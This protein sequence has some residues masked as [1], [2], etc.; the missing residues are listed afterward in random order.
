M[1]NHARVL[2]PRNLVRRV[3]VG[4]DVVA[5]RR[6]RIELPHAAD[7]MRLGQIDRVFLDRED[8][9]QILVPRDVDGVGALIAAGD[10]VAP[11]DPRGLHV[12]GPRAQRVTFPL[13]GREAR[14]GRERIGRRLGT[15]VHPD[16]DRVSQVVAAY[17]PRDDAA[18]VILF[19]PDRDAA[20]PVLSDPRRLREALAF[21]G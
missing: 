3:A 9:E 4:L 13:T 20:R 8:R 6:P 12:R 11:A 5:R 7:D 14:R 15:A 10:A 1:R 21:D 16:R 18:V 2:E 17:F 19:A